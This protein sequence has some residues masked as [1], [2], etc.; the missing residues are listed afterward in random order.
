MDKKFWGITLSE[1]KKGKNVRTNKDVYLS[2]YVTFI[3]CELSSRRKL[4]VNF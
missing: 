4:A 1:K 2:L 3:D